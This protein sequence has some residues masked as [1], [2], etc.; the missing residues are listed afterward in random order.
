MALLLPSIHTVLQAP[1]LV[2]APEEEE[3]WTTTLMLSPTTASLVAALAAAAAPQQAAQAAPASAPQAP[4]PTTT[5]R[6]KKK[7]PHG[8]RQVGRCRACGGS[9]ICAPHGLRKETCRACAPHRFCPH[10]RRRDLVCSGCARGAPAV[11]V[12]PPYAESCGAPSKAEHARRIQY[13]RWMGVCPA[14]PPPLPAWARV[15]LAKRERGQ[16]C[17]LAALGACACARCRLVASERDAAAAALRA[18]ADESAASPPAA[19]GAAAEE[20]EGAFF[21]AEDE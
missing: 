5:K 6:M 21:C 18:L 11:C 1:P 10:G 4:T 7:C 19:A 16:R 13:A 17:V 15:T 9:Q 3:A 2:G 8:V 14:H 20:A 12:C